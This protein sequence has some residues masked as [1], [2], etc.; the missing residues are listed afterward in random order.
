MMRILSSQSV[1]ALLEYLCT[2]AI[3]DRETAKNRFNAVLVLNLWCFWFTSLVRA[4]E[5]FLVRLET[6]KQHQNLIRLFLLFD[7]RM[8]A[9]CAG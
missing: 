4:L 8:T 7:V 3:S 1:G 6:G 9:G 5:I 2:V